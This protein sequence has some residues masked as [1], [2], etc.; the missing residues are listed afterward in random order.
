MLMSAAPVG[1]RR[2]QLGGYDRVLLLSS[3]ASLLERLPLRSVRL[4]VFSLDQQREVYRNEDFSPA[5]F[6]AVAH[7]L[8]QLELGTVDY[9]VLQNRRGHVDLL[10]DLIG[11][12]V[13]SDAADAV[14]F[15]GPKPRHYDK[16]GRSMLPGST[17]Q[18]P[19]FY[20]QFRPFVVGA[21]FPD[22][23]MSAVKQMG[24]K[25]FNVFSP[26]DFAEAIR[27]ISRTLDGSR[28]P[29]TGL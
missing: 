6:D 15:V 29:L 12:A 22:V 1:P 3:L 10:S 26:A 17:G 14:L 18:P 23:I 27:E 28:K 20:V 5:D 8:S 2:V 16:V 21:N 11:E 13:K 25:T 9:D 4:V 19:F 24:G 7:S